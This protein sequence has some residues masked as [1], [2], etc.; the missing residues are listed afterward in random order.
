MGGEG[1]G[2][3]C[4]CEERGERGYREGIGWKGVG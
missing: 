2:V 4:R 1:V 3:T